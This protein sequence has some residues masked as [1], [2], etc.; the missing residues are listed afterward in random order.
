MSTPHENLRFLENK[1]VL[2]SKNALTTIPEI[3]FFPAF[4]SKNTPVVPHQTIQLVCKKIPKMQN[5]RF[6]YCNRGNSGVLNKMQIEGNMKSYCPELIK[7]C[8]F[9]DLF[10]LLCKKLEEHFKILLFFITNRGNS[11]VL[12]KK[13]KIRGKLN[14][15]V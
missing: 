4:W 6:F 10:Q 2:Q 15:T 13:Q 12:K 11:S 3:A 14:R 1:K 9:P 5:S 7:I 8:Y